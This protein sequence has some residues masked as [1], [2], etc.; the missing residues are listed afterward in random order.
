[1]MYTNRVMIEQQHLL[2][3]S[4]QYPSLT[5]DQQYIRKVGMKM[6]NNSMWTGRI[7]DQGRCGSCYAF[8][9]TSLINYVS[10][11]ENNAITSLEASEQ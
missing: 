1:M 5:I 2:L 10:S 11:S 8:A 4:V 6:V 7:R 3:T 9:A